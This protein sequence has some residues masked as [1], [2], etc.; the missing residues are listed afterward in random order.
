MDFTVRPQAKLAGYT[1]AT[2][3]DAG[4]FA[5]TGIYEL[6]RDEILAG[7]GSYNGGTGIDVVLVLNTGSHPTT[8]L[9][10]IS[11]TGDCDFSFPEWDQ[12]LYLGENLFYD[13][14]LHVN[15]TCEDIHTGDVRML[16]VPVDWHMVSLT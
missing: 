13:P 4:A 7:S 2:H 15:N 8:V 6:H 5:Y 12:N 11:F 14:Y 16:T 1:H 10:T 9:L 3:P